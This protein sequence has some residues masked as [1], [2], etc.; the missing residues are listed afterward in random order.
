M[1]LE[2]TNDPNRIEAGELASLYDGREDILS[3]FSKSMHKMFVLDGKRLAGAV[4][5]ISEGVETALLV[6]LKAFPEYG[7]DVRLQ[8]LGEIEKELSDRRV[9]AF[10]SREDLEVYEDAGYGRC[11][12]AWTLFREGFDEADYLPWGFRFENDFFPLKRKKRS[13]GTEAS[14]DAH[15]PGGKK[16][17]TYSEGLGRA[18]FEEVNS[19][20]TEAFFGRPH[21]VFKTEKAFTNSSYVVSA[22]DKDKPVG[23]ARAVSDGKDYATILNVAVLP[24]YQG[25][26]IGK[27]LV[28]RLSSVIDAKTVVLN[29][30]AGAVGFYNKLKEYRRNKYVFEKHIPGERTEN[31]LPRKEE[32]GKEREDP[33]FTA[34][35]RRN[36]MFTPKGFRFPDEYC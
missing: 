8:L 6:D 33:E 2:F 25:M 32:T 23:V 24:E 12:N 16:G 10:G 26:A 14:D 1:S 30:H 15:V 21:D 5:V 27:T 19:I 4:R 11:K 34:F 18:S 31:P 3:L 17:I 35:F 22:F 28:L 7:S 9:M 36:M 20:L 29:T 13:G